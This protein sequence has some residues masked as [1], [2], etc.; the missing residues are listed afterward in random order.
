M[1]QS[2]LLCCCLCTTHN[3]YVF[4]LSDSC[5]PIQSGCKQTQVKASKLFCTNCL[6]FLSLFQASQCV[7]MTSTPIFGVN[8]KCGN[9]NLR[10]S[11]NLKHSLFVSPANVSNLFG[12][13]AVFALK[14]TCVSYILASGNCCELMMVSLN[15][16]W[17]TLSLISSVT[18]E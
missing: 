11:I 9:L 12:V 18:T 1:N 8:L 3:W 17:T 10:W 4:I 15:S 14:V 7:L 2:N 13:F 5:F 16:T 6:A